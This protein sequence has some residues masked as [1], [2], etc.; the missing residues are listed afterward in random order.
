MGVRAALYAAHEQGLV[1]L[2]VD[3]GALSEDQELPAAAVLTEMPK[4]FS[5]HIACGELTCK[6]G[7]EAHKIASR[8]SFF[9]M[10]NEGKGSLTKEDVIQLNTRHVLRNMC[11][12]PCAPSGT[13]ICFWSD[14]ARWTCPAIAQLCRQ[15]P[16][17]SRTA[18]AS[19]APASSPERARV[20]GHVG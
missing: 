13:N 11:F 4:P 1:K 15:P 3:D 6:T 16:H 2:I 8:R 14:A 10:I 5:G 12:R 9:G 20:A 19:E 18:N 7:D 17:S